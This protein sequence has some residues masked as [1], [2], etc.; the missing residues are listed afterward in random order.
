MKPVLLAL[1]LLGCGDDDAPETKAAPATVRT[2]DPCIAIRAEYD[3]RMTFGELSGLV[4]GN[5]A[6]NPLFKV[7]QSNFRQEHPRCFF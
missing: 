6:L 5:G 7:Q 4:A 2:E 3:R 1:L